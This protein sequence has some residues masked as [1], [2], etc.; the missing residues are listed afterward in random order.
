MHASINQHARMHQSTYMRA[1]NMHHSTCMLVLI[2][3]HASINIHTWNQHASLNMHACINQH[4]CII[5]HACMHASINMHQL[6]N[7][8]NDNSFITIIAISVVIALNAPTLLHILD[9]FLKP[10]TYQKCAGSYGNLESTCYTLQARLTDRSKTLYS[11]CV[12]D[13]LLI[14]QTLN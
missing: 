11:Y 10:V 7:P 2:N 3:M 1:L 5:Q 6:K 13:F 14:W 4:A 8:D 12:M 9:I